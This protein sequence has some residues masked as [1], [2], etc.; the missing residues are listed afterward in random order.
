MAAAKKKKR[1]KPRKNVKVKAK[2]ATAAPA[3][4]KALDA[5]WRSFIDH[6]APDKPLTEA[7]SDPKGVASRP[8]TAAAT[9]KKAKKKAATK[10]KSAAK[11]RKKATRK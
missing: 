1:A 9:K 5:G 2:K 8:R 10:K 7:W 11:P 6:A 4:L 3:G